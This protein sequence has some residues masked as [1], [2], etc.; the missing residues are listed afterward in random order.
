MRIFIE[1]SGHRWGNTGDAM[2]FEVAMA[3]LRD[4]WP[5]A[6]I[7]VHSL[8]REPLQRIDAAARALEPWGAR[9]WSIDVPASLRGRPRVMKLVAQ[10]AL[11]VKRHDPRLGREYLDAIRG[12]DLVL[13]SGAGSLND[14]FRRNALAVL[15]T[16]ELAIDSGAVTALLGQGLGPMHDATLRRRAAE[17]LP[18]VEF[19]ALREGVAGP[20]LLASLGVPR[21]RVMV[22]GD[23]AIAL[24]H[25]ARPAQ[26]GNALGFN[27]RAAPY[28]GID[29]AMLA[30]IG[31]IVRD[32]GKPLL[33]IAMSR[34]VGEEDA[35]SV[36]RAIGV[37]TET[38]ALDAIA[39][40]RVVVAGSYH[41]AVLAL[42][43]GIPAIAIANS[44]YYA[45]KFRGLAAQFGDA[46]RVLIASDTDF[47]A[48]LRNAIDEAWQRADATR[49]SLLD[50]AARQ[51]AL[52]ESAYDQVIALVEGRRRAR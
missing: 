27:L 30:R 11:L 6:E 26:L 49:A 34:N 23:D 35:E 31:A 13:V 18:R 42:S 3:R 24:A 32:A 36:R 52:S 1:P 46:C 29:D 37:D 15:A 48:R 2:M 45:D 20:P 17:V 16:L 51:V 47:D 19:I 4:R 9:A 28:S 8:E 50:A 7:T 21:E 10:L 14:A 33:G 39:H 44:A 40:C 12:A 22:T 38:N 5:D 43:M 41:A 25:R